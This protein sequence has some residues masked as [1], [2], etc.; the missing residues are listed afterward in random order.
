MPLYNEAYLKSLSRN[1]TI[2]ENTVLFSQTRQRETFDIFLSHSFLD[3]EAVT[4]LFIELSNYGYS[5]YVDWIVDPHLDR[6]KVTKESASLIR[7]RLKSSKS[8]LLA[9]SKN[10]DISKWI[11]WELGYVDGHTNLCAL[12]PVAKTNE[13]GYSFL[14]KEYLLLYPFIKKFVNRAQ[15]EKLWVVEDDTH[16]VIFDDWLKAHNQPFERDI[17]IAAY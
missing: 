3:K 7:Q 8:L 2:N 11:P 6:E 14:R 10:A 9:I 15:V 17:N 12:I 13:S 16:Y 5:V 4:G 1:R